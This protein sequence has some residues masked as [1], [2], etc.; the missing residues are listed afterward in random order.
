[1]FIS[2]W[3]SSYILSGVVHGGIVA[4]LLATG[5]SDISLGLVSAGQIPHAT[6]NVDRS[7]KSDRLPVTSADSVTNTTTILKNVRA[8]QRTVPGASVTPAR[9]MTLEN[10]DGERA[11][12]LAPAPLLPC[13][14]MASS[15]SDLNMSSLIGRC[16]V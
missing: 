16:F 4:A 8:P 11:P 7:L 10:D 5:V 1:M 13:E 3:L 6:T 9:P 14:T 2:P 12:K 15:V